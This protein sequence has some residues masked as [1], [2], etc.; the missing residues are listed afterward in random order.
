MIDESISTHV[1]KLVAKAEAEATRK[2]L[3]EEKA[4]KNRD[5][6]AATAA[7]APLSPPFNHFPLTLNIGDIGIFYAVFIRW[8][9]FIITF[10]L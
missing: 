10:Y 8:V 6:S 3:A 1:K 2:R 7:V 5:K 9:F 4:K